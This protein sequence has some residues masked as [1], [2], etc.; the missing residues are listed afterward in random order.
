MNSVAMNIVFSE[1]CRDE[2]CF[3]DPLVANFR[4]ALLALPHRLGKTIYQNE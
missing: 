2:Q 3:L 4:H 1:P